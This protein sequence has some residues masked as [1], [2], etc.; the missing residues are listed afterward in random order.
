MKILHISA[1]NSSSGA[2]IACVRLHKALLSDS[3]DSKVL[4]LN[5][6]YINS[7]EYSFYENTLIRKLR[8]TLLTFLDRWIVYFY[9]RRGKKLFSPGLFGVKIYNLSEVLAADI[10]HLHWTNHAFINI[11]DL[12]KINKPI[13]WTMHDCWLFTGGC[14]HFFAC[15][16][17]KYSCGGCPVLE[18]KNDDDLSNFVFRRKQK[19]LPELNIKYVAISNWMKKHAKLSPILSEQSIDVIPSGIDIRI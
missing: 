12:S 16:K 5:N 1:A 9:L 17:F 14:H 2:G 8:R 11:S 3:V 13:I 6:Q 15:D 7:S 10:I 19:L 18:S 4:F